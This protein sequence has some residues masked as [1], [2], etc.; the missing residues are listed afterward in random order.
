[1]TKVRSSNSSSETT[2]KSCPI[3]PDQDTNEGQSK[4]RF[5]WTFDTTNQLLT[6]IKDNEQRFEKATNKNSVWNFIASAL[7]G[8][9]VTGLQCR[10]RYYTLKK[11]YRKFNAESNKTGNKR[12][13]PFLYED[14]MADIL[15]NDPTFSPVVAKGTLKHDQD[16]TSEDDDEEPGT[17]SK[18]QQQPHKKKKTQFDHLKEYME[19][20]DQHFL[21][22]LKDMNE[23]QNKLM[24]KLIEKL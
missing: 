18:S 2:S 5:D 9:S 20:R 14:L 1:M 15:Q 10:E 17:S 24:E 4:T 7:K 16:N 22:A 23:K 12:P 19:E 11:A 6:C 13:R 3:R 21:D 8:L